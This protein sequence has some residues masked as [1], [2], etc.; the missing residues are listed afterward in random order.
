M[1]KPG[2]EMKVKLDVLIMQV[3][4]NG[5]R[6]PCSKA[7]GIPLRQANTLSE[8]NFGSRDCRE[9]RLRPFHVDRS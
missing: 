2:K 5:V 3:I 8:L 9:A 1:D 7:F 4:G 6:H